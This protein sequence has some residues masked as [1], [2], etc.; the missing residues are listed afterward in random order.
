MFN[1]K[2]KKSV[3][4]VNTLQHSFKLSA[5]SIFLLIFCQFFNLI[6][7]SLELSWWMLSIIGICL[8]WQILIT[9]NK[10]PQPSKV[11]IAILSVT[12]C[13]LLA[14]AAKSLGLLATMLHLLCL[15]YILKSF[16]Q[17][18]RADFY[19]IILLGL[20]VV[21]S[22]LIFQQSLY[23]SLIIFCIL[24]VNFTLIFDYFLPTKKYINTLKLSSKIFIQS[25]P[26]AIFLFIVF[27]KLSPLWAVPTAKSAK[28]GLSDSVKVGDIANLALSDEL[29][30]RVKFEKNVPNYSQLY[31][32][33]IV[34]ENFDGRSWNTNINPSNISQY[35]FDKTSA[36]GK[37]VSYQV[38]AS[39]TY[40]NWLFGLDLARIDITKAQSTD[41]RHRQ[42]YS[43]YSKKELT[44]N[45]SYNVTSYIEA[46]LALNISQLSHQKNLTIPEQ[47]NPKLAEKAKNLRA[48]YQN[49]ESLINAVLATFN[50]E[51]YR[52][53]LNPPAL[54]N[55]SLDQFYFETKAG[56]CEHFASSFT[57]LMR[58]AGI[59]ARLV[60]G[61]MGGEYNAQANYYSI[62]QRDAHAWSEV[63]LQGKGWTRVDPTAAINPERV[64]RGFSEQLLREQAATSENFSLLRF[65]NNNAFINRIRLQLEAIDY[66]WTR[67]VIGYTADKQ[68]KFLQN[69]VLALKAMLDLHWL[70][71]MYYALLLISAVI[72]WWIILQ[73]NQARK[74][75][76]INDYYQQILEH[77]AKQGIQKS[78]DMTPKDFVLV[79]KSKWPALAIE[80]AKFTQLYTSIQYQQLN[81]NQQVSV[82]KA[83][84]K[85][86]QKI[87]KMSQGK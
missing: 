24:I 61:Y 19:Q 42:D 15:S 60:T 46:P 72:L 50:Q 70:T 62:Y 17:N 21:V 26:L 57:F 23:F 64:E 54:I 67:W 31:W 30:F 40:Q 9:K 3:K 1:K 34:M 37:R 35:P 49:N 39:P 80:F 18:K 53:T 73:I 25:I 87:K 11:L 12:G 78:T 68:N 81:E 71:L 41:I 10:T 86:Y 2:A 32:R 83:L 36:K 22:S 85:S 27:P 16:E 69:I 45:T 84:K 29:A 75:Q 47:S 33:T 48:K 79:V 7:L 65:S 82:V 66:N 44:Q 74:T 55:N 77:L 58:A 28:T 76:N 6:T 8:V 56:F 43:L 14:F 13:L 20:F 4:P 59:P 52:Y 63:W 51:T 38:I 5:N